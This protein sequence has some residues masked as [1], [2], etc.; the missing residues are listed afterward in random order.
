MVSLVSAV[1]HNDTIPPDGGTPAKKNEADKPYSNFKAM[2]DKHYPSYENGTGDKEAI[3]QKLWKTWDNLKANDKQNKI[4]TDEKQQKAWVVEHVRIEKTS[5]FLN[6]LAPVP[7]DDERKLIEQGLNI[8]EPSRFAQIA[9]THEKYHEE[10]K[11][12]YDALKLMVSK[13]DIICNGPSIATLAGDLAFHGLT[14]NNLFDTQG[15]FTK[16]IETVFGFDE[17][18]FKAFSWNDLKNEFPDLLNGIYAMGAGGG[19]DVV[20]AAAVISNFAEAE[21]K[22][23]VATSIQ[24]PNDKQKGNFPAEDKNGFRVVKPDAKKVAKDAETHPIYGELQKEEVAAAAFKMDI[25]LI[26]MLASGSG[27]GSKKC[28]EKKDVETT[29]TTNHTEGEP[30]VLKEIRAAYEKFKAHVSQSNCKSI[31]LCDT[32]GD[33]TIKGKFGRDQI[34][35]AFATKAAEDLGK[36]LYLEVKGP[37]V[38]LESNGL[39]VLISLLRE[40]GNVHMLQTSQASDAAIKGID[41]FTTHCIQPNGT[42]SMIKA[43]KDNK[44]TAA[45]TLASVLASKIFSTSEN[46]TKL[47]SVL[48]NEKRGFVTD[49]RG[50]EP[51][52]KALITSVLWVEVKAKAKAVAVADDPTNPNYV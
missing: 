14:A 51:M 42:L 44:V 43:M 35:L 10:F 46:L 20:S 16:N 19:A 17:N 21:E 3:A 18:N 31:V 32:G 2:F 6:S 37:G 40:Y 7:D 23:V 50:I 22:G 26:E 33:I 34:S 52:L 5:I 29:L 4:P 11:E 15:D 36:K 24:P 13:D 1:S 45:P 30:D 27:S 9:N 39:E 38:D 41:D 48:P 49:G 25:T 28:W 47:D 12:I 8:L